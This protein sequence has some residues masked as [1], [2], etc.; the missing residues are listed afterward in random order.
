MAITSPEMNFEN[1]DGENNPHNRISL[2]T[3]KDYREIGQKYDVFLANASVAYRKGKS[4]LHD[5]TLYLKPGEILGLIG[6]SGAG[7]STCMRVM[8]GQI[9]PPQLTHGFAV[10]AGCRAVRDNLKLI[11]KIGYVPQL[12]YLS[13]YEEFSALDNCLFFGRN[14]CIPKKQILKRAR[15]ILQ[16]LGFENEELLKKPV[17]Y[18]SGGERKRVSIAVGLINTPR[19]LFLDEPTTGLDPHLRIGVLNFLL[20][21]NKEFNTTMIIVSHDLEI[22]DYCTKVAI[23]NYGELAG[24][25]KPKELIE[26]LPSKGKNLTVHFQNY[27]FRKNLKQVQNIS[28]VEYVLNTG[29][30][31]IK[32]FS[33]SIEE[34]PN[35]IKQLEQIGL[36]ISHF[37]LDHSVFLDY[38]RIKGKH[39]TGV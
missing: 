4:I 20:K 34:Y 9:K 32:I 6:G 15:E 14:Y 16:I 8:T 24:F 23:L 27:N 19:V 21:I 12:E 5:I 37:S 36:E 13:L 25:G 3:I 11:Q 7:K 2:Y 26:S 38:F 35:I 39:I 18:L 10:T 31:Q 29:R 1:S 22:A 30:N 28:G 33:D 17:K